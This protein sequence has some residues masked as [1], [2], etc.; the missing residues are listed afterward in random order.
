MGDEDLVIIEV[1][2][3]GTLTIRPSDLVS[4]EDEQ[5]LTA[6]EILV[7]EQQSFEDGWYDLAEFVNLLDDSPTV[8]M[9]LA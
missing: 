6:D 7:L 5:P 4:D 3:K 9:E 8:V 2:I 1:T